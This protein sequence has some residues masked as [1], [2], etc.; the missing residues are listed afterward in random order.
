VT[1]GMKK[2]GDATANSHSIVALFC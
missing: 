2:I 1:K